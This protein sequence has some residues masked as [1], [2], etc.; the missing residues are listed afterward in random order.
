MSLL[1]GSSRTTPRAGYRAAIL[2]LTVALVCAGCLSIEEPA[3]S[4][5]AAA[6]TA[7]STQTPRDPNELVV[8]VPAD[9]Q[10]FL[11]IAG[12][13][14][15]Q[16]LTDLLYDPLY[17]LD[18]DSR[19]QP[20]LAADYPSVSSDGLTWT[21]RQRNAKFADGTAITAADSAF[22][23]SVA[24]S[25]ACP[26][27]RSF[28]RVVAETF[29]SAA[30]A[31]PSTLTITLRQRSS[32]FLAEVLARLPILSQWAVR[33][34]TQ[35]LIVGAAALEPG[36]AGR[37]V[38]TITDATNQDA[39]LNDPLPFGCRLS[40]YTTTLEKLLRD[41][42]IGLPPRQGFTG[43]TGDVD[44]EAYA[45]ALLD[46]VSLLDRAVSSQGVEQAAAALALL[47]PVGHPL[48]GG[49]YSIESYTP[50][51]QIVLRANDEQAGGRPPIAKVTLRIIRDPA[52]A[53]TALLTGDADWLLR[54]EA[55]QVP[56]VAAAS[57]MRSGYRPLHSQRVIVFNVRPGR[58]YAE[59][60]ARR[61]F[62]MCLDR[63]SLADSAAGG[64]QIVA[65]TP[66]SAGSWALDTPIGTARDAVGAMALLEGAGWRRAADGIFAR[67]A[68]RLSS[69]IAVRPSRPDLLAFADAAA[70][71]LAECGIELQVRELDLTGQ[72]LV[73]QL[74]WPNDFETVLVARDLGDDPDQDLQPFESVHATSADNP[75]DANPG[76]YVSAEVDRLILAGREQVDLEARRTTYGQLAGV[77]A[78]D[79]PAWPIWY[80]TAFS[81]LS[82]RVTSPSG[83]IDPR[84]ERFWW[85]LESWSL[86]GGR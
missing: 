21:I 75:A 41:A 76:G 81:A 14:T 29:A 24:A 48:A 63:A 65:R 40:D 31:Q 69:S 1:R 64:R 72:L 42:G 47:D 3:P 25:P 54:V 35:A 80:D 84:A 9:P 78:Q 33:S 13:D 85:D 22:S 23:L 7:G 60:V 77:L 58:V 26:Y 30:A 5:S 49:P 68:Q 53:A 52:V 34:A 32:P 27:G 36:Q 51:S 17:R 20:D 37:T 83:A 19:P 43:A 18:E 8:A 10:G 62:S 46:R 4:A 45:G 6:A 57:S 82:S 61:A 70:Q 39:C 38:V 73:T 56:A 28:C 74:Q 11:P 50:G 16:L 44:A 71:Q 79:V 2:L 59:A 15:T 55:S 66:T 86:P 67:G 12:D